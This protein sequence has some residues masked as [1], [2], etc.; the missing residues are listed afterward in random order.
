MTFT[1]TLICT[2]QV[3]FQVHVA[4]ELTLTHNTVLSM[5]QEQDQSFTFQLGQ[6]QLV[7][8][9]HLIQHMATNYTNQ[10]TQ[11]QFLFLICRI[12]PNKPLEFMSK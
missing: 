9:N 1:L 3:W 4:Q 10:I 12:R 2:Q 7:L 5:A 11:I 8:Q 6:V